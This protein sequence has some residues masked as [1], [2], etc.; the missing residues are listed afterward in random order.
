[1]ASMAPSG[2]APTVVRSSSSSSS[3]PGMLGGE[4]L[5][6][7]SLPPS[8]PTHHHQIICAAQGQ[9]DRLLGLCIRYQK[10][11][12][13]HDKHA[14]CHGVCPEVPRHLA[15]HLAARRDE[16]EGSLLVTLGGDGGGWG[17]SLS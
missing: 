3:M 17:R 11:P 2:A 10:L 15:E 1:M 5:C 13:V 9:R 14:T 4:S 8:A 16:L 7:T 6:V 12:T